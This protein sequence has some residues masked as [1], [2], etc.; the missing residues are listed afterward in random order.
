MI[1]AGGGWLATHPEKELITRRYL[2]HRGSLTEEALAR[3]AEVDDLEP[4]RVDDADAAPE[5]PPDKKSTLAE[6]RRGAVLAAV[7]ASGAKRVGDLGCGEGVLTADLLADRAIEHV[8]AADVSARS[9]G[10]AARRLRLETMPDARRARISLIQSSLTY[11]D[12][13]LA[14]LDAAVLMEVIE[15]VDPERLG[16]L[17]ATV[18]GDATPATVIVTT[19]NAE[20]NVVFETLPA[21]SFRHRD[22]RFEW[23]RAEFAS[24]SDRVADSYGGIVVGDLARRTASRTANAE[25]FRA[26][27][28]RYC[29]PTDGLTG[30]Q[31]APFQVLASE[32]RTYHE[33]PHAE[34]LALTDRLVAADAAM[35]R[36]TRRTSVD[37]TDDDSIRAAIQWWSELADAGG[38]GM[39]VKPAANLT[40]TAKSI[41]QPGLKVRGREYLRIIYGPDYTEP[42]NLDRLRQRALGHKRSMALREYALGLEALDRAARGEPLWRGA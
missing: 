42:A 3:L 34:H 8:V 27:Y 10:I 41:V 40:R 6:Q 22:H 7:R 14:G 16:A 18:F 9:L 20:Y 17:E 24:W 5:L 15:H 31:L 11:R 30:V 12:A 2:R 35:F 38:E 32:G 21:G 28:R 19:P 13:R 33:L 26:A 4:E 37:L 36:T 1:R 29:W 25:L 39:V 23:T